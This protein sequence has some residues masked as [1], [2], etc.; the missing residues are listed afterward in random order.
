MQ[1]SRFHLYLNVLKLI[2]KFIPK[3]YWSD[4]LPLWVADR[5]TDSFAD[6]EATDRCVGGMRL[7]SYFSPGKQTDLHLPD[8]SA[9]LCVAG[10]HVHSCKLKCPWYKLL[11]CGV[12]LNLENSKAN[13]M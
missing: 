7:C 10:K 4:R 11:K 8:K 13:L 1:L 3:T 5:L 6:G 9:N 12:L 2:S